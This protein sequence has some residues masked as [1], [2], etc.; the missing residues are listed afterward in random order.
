MIRY[1]VCHIRIVQYIKMKPS[2]VLVTST[3]VK[4]YIEIVKANAWD[5]QDLSLFKMIKHN[6]YK[7]IKGTLIFIKSTC[8][9]TLS[10]S[11]LGHTV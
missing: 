5:F 4:G 10:G 6:F 2:E 11:I 3:Y 1:Y 8:S 7:V 9:L